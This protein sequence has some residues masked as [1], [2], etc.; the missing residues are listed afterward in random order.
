MLKNENNSMNE[1][2]VPLSEK[3]RKIGTWLVFLY[4]FFY[5]VRPQE[6]IPGFAEVRFAGILFLITTIWGVLH[7]RPFVLKTPLSIILILAFVFFLSGLGAINTGPFKLFVNYIIEVFPQCL[8]IYVIFDS[9]ERILNLVKLWLLIYFLMALITIKNGG[10]GPGDFTLDPNDAAMALA[11][12]IPFFAYALR[13]L[14]LTA[15][16]RIFCKIAIITLI[17]AIVVTGSRGGFL[18]LLA[19]LLL[20]WWF[21]RKKIR[22]ALISFFIGLAIVVGGLSLLPTDYAKEIESINDPNDETRLE[23]LNTWEV[24]WE[25][26]KDNPFLGVGA[27]GFKYNAGFYQRMTSWWTEEHKSLQGRVTHSLVF[28][29]ISEVGTIGALVYLYV[30]IYLPLKLNGIRKKLDESLEENRLILFWSLTLIVSMGGF[31]VAG[32]FISVAYYPHIP[33]W[34]TMYAILT[35]YLH[36][37]INEADKAGKL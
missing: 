26:Y 22:I 35:R 1:S 12:G 25:M 17:V 30:L 23:R 9:K 29:I 6:I 31:F 36:S 33:V 4:L 27:G 32:A 11:M 10:L 5:Y 34:I 18:G 37:S 7:F 28:Q 19:V 15:K 8:A 14:S 2:Q 24:A 21:S 3:D 20:L 16:Q 13:F